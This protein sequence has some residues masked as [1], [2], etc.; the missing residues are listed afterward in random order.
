MDLFVRYA[1]LT[2]PNR[3]RAM[4]ADFSALRT[5]LQAVLDAS[6]HERK[7]VK[8]LIHFAVPAQAL[9]VRAIE[10]DGIRLTGSLS[11]LVGGEECTII[12]SD[13]RM[14]IGTV[15][16]CDAGLYVRVDEM[17]STVEDI[18]D[19]GVQ[20]G[21]WVEVNPNVLVTK[22]RFIKA[23]NL[24]AISCFAIVICVLRLLLEDKRTLA[25]ATEFC[26]C[27]DGED[28]G[29]HENCDG[30]GGICSPEDF[31]ESI[32]IE[33]LAITEEN[34][35]DEYSVAIQGK[36]LEQIAKEKNIPYKAIQGMG[37]ENIM[38]VAFHVDGLSERGHEEGIRAAIT[39]L[40]AYL[41]E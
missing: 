6:F 23:R 21:D 11:S 30:F 34:N 3:K 5:R 40:S 25:R 37:N 24:R 12:T 16:K 38:A 41:S 27:R 29:C 31:E 26:L 33:A 13:E 36:V 28:S 18:A 8:R 14:Y 1:S 15:R 9:R 35:L 19:L 2:G 17:V 4:Q 39:L 22:S 20:T 7:Q 32:R 10:A